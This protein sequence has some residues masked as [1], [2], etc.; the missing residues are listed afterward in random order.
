MRKRL[1]AGIIAWLA[2]TSFMVAHSDTGV[3]RG[4]VQDPT[5]AIFINGVPCRCV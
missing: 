4:I 2:M 3:I 1:M 5:G